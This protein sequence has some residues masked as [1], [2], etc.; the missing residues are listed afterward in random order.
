MRTVKVTK[1]DFIER[2]QVN[3]DN[4]RNIFEKAQEGFKERMIE[5][6]ERRLEDAR[7]GREIQMFIA[8][9]PPEDHTHEYDRVLTMAR[10]STEDVLE[11][12][13][14]E[15]GSYVMDDWAWK[16]AFLSNSMTYGA[17]N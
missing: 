9:D 17:V 8:L 1:A 4:H 11:L 14:Q 15:F 10:M 16:R 7:K 2:V 3:R 6:L 13:E 5:E 12:T